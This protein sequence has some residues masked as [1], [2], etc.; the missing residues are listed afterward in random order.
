MLSGM[1]ET[2]PSP[3]TPGY[4]MPVERGKIREF[5][6]STGSNAADYL[7]AAAPPVPPTF[8]RTAAFWHPE[9]APSPMAGLNLNLSRIL[10]GEQEYVFFGPPPHAG[11]ELTV[12]S[13]LESVT[14]K[15][16]RR[17][18][19]MRIIVTVEDFTDR[20]GRLVAQGRSTLIETGQA[21]R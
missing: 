11:D 8:L 13:R 19:T 3:A 14:E 20:D 1:P 18:G 9:D 6:S 5:A 10:H 12:R 4:V 2:H 21:P 15:E 17:G 16:G 7:E